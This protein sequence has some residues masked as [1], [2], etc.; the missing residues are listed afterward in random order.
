M[1]TVGPAVAQLRFQLTSFS[2]GSPCLTVGTAAAE[3]WSALA[4]QPATARDGIDAVHR[5]AKVM[6]RTRVRGTPYARMPLVVVVGARRAPLIFP[7]VYT[8]PARATG[9]FLG[10]YECVKTHRVPSHA[11]RRRSSPFCAR[12]PTSPLRLFVPPSVISLGGISRGRGVRG[13]G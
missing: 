13:T 10:Y 2:P 7:G 3:R 11:F 8:T 5:T 12:T 9:S 6:H 1:S 4:S